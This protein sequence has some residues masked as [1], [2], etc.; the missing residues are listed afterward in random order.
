MRLEF[1]VGHSAESAQALSHA[2]AACVRGAQ[3]SFALL[4]SHLQIM[5]S[6][7]SGKTEVASQRRGAR[8]LGHTFAWLVGI[9]W[10][11]Q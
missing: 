11:D 2:R 3:A 6:A 10:R 4:R 9:D 5:A 1:G 8:L 7:G